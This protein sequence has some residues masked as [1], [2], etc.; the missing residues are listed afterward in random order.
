MKGTIKGMRITCLVCSIICLASIIALFVLD[1]IDDRAIY[2]HRIMYY[3]CFGISIRACAIAVFCAS[4]TVAALSFLL[5]K[6]RVLSTITAAISLVC[7]IFHFRFAPLCTRD[8]I[9]SV[10]YSWDKQGDIGN[11]MILVGLA[12]IPLIVLS[13]VGISKCKEFDKATLNG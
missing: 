13:S 9:M 5:K 11:A 10:I 6:Q 8:G 2:T 7:G 12:C 3:M 1:S 4:T